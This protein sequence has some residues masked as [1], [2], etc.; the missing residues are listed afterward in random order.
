[1]M[2]NL[3]M[4]SEKLSSSLFEMT[5]NTAKFVECASNVE[6]SKKLSDLLSSNRNS[7]SAATTTTSDHF[8]MIIDYCCKMTEISE[9]DFRIE[10]PSAG[11]ESEKDFSGFVAKIQIKNAS[12]LIAFYEYI[13]NLIKVF[14]PFFCHLLI[15]TYSC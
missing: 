2:S 15:F 7:Q 6:I 1:M 4:T 8:H 9:K 11:T 12:F 10:N 14:T 13:I 5:F 3:I